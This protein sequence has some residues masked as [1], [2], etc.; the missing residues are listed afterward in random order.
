V[1]V[2]DSEAG[3][4]DASD[5]LATRGLHAVLGGA[6]ILRGVEFGLK[7]GEV[8]GV[9]GPSGAGKSTL[10]RI[11]AGEL[12]ASGGD[13][14]LHG[15][16]IT[17]LPLWRRA[18]AGMGYVPQTPSV[19]FDLSVQDNIRTFEQLARAPRRSAEER[20]RAVGLED[21]L[22]VPAG[23]LSGGERRRLELLRALI[24]EPGVLIC[25]EP[26]TGVDPKGAERVRGALRDVAS[27]G[28]AVLLADHR[29][30]EALTI[31]DSA[32]LLVD[33]RVELRAPAAEFADDPAVKRRYLG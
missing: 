16:R 33:G 15:R 23:E 14:Y 19:L 17:R 22:R 24:G 9:L 31:C 4:L 8:L 20:A 18:R 5:V 30:Q 13:V 26:L 7:K 21:R 6:E 32:L 1:S 11:I 29:V 28:T 2:S 27:R 12:R 10:F 25:D 3:E